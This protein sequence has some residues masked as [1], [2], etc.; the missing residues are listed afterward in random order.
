MKKQDKNLQGSK[1]LATPAKKQ[2]ITMN[3]YNKSII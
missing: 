1:L 3:N 2:N